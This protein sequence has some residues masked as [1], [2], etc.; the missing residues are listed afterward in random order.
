M[1]YS[2]YNSL[3]K[4][5]QEH[6]ILF[7][8][9]YDKYLIVRKMQEQLLVNYSA[10]EVENKDRCFYNLLLNEKFVLE[11]NIDEIN[12]L[13]NIIQKN[14]HNLSTYT[15]IINPT[16]N[17]NFRCWYCYENHLENTKMTDSTLEFVKKHISLITDK[18][19]LE[20]IELSF[21]GGEPLIFYTEIVLPLMKYAKQR[22]MEKDII[23]HIGFT[24]NGYLLSEQIINSMKEF[25][26]SHFQ[27]TLDGYREDHNKVRTSVDKEGSYDRIVSNLKILLKNDIQVILRINYTAKNIDKCILIVE[28]LSDLTSEMK[29]CLEI[30]LQH[31]WQDKKNNID[32]KL[33]TVLKTFI[34]KEFKTSSNILDRI[35]NPCYADKLNETVINYNGDV[36]KCTARDFTQQNRY[37]YIQENGEIKYESDPNAIR[38][39]SILKNAPCQSCRIAPLCNGGCSQTRIENYTKEYCL[40]NYSEKQKD[41]VILDRFEYLFMQ[42]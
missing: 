32:N 13:K 38:A 9:L 36:F 10:L 8:S 29:R 2:M 16:L 28:D 18:E 34:Q 22:C 11:D 35:R 37:G 25:P 6:S 21:F 39:N 23:L 26:I 15:L 27:V 33:S 7:N 14:N 17:C 3:I 20:K 30:N 4:I 41:K 19:E 40:L 31:V 5:N 24:T 42:K 12:T 1:K